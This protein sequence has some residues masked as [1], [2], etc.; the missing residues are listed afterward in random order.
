[1]NEDRSPPLAADDEEY[2]FQF[3]LASDQS[4]PCVLVGKIFFDERGK[5]LCFSFD[6]FPGADQAKAAW[7]AYMAGL[8]SQPFKRAPAASTQP[9]TKEKS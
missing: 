7:A 1:M 2:R 9:A 5:V 4:R 3:A 8:G 6:P